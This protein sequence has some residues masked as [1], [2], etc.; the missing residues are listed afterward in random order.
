MDNPSYNHL[1]VSLRSILIERS[2]A[3]T[4]TSQDSRFWNII[5]SDQPILWQNFTVTQH[6]GTL[7][8]SWLTLLDAA[9]RNV[10]YFAVKFSTQYPAQLCTSRRLII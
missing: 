2:L 3:M 5:L 6:L 10:S 4:T 9:C 8:R 7:K 1:Q